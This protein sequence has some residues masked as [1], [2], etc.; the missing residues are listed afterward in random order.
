MVTLRSSFLFT[1]SPCTLYLSTNMQDCPK[2]NKEEKTD[3]RTVQSI[4]SGGIERGK[5]ELW[6]HQETNE[7][8]YLTAGYEEARGWCKNKLYIGPSSMKMARR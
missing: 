8:P 4:F 5:T 3:H 6:L 7:S 1:L 2:H